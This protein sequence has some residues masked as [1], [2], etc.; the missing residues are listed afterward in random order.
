MLP[1]KTSFIPAI[2]GSGLDCIYRAILKKY[3][4]TL[5]LARVYKILEVTFSPFRIK[6]KKRLPSVDFL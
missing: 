1:G 2:R 4:R 3:T 6:I 5:Y